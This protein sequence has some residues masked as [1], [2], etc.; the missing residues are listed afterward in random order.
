MAMGGKGASVFVNL[1]VGWEKLHI[2]ENKQFGYILSFI[3]NL[4]VY[5]LPRIQRMHEEFHQKTMENQY[6]VWSNAH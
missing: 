5:Y 1:Y 6:A 2:H 4:Y 3:D